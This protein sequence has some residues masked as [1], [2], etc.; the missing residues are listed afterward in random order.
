MRQVFKL[1]NMIRRLLLSKKSIEER[2]AKRKGQCRKCGQCCTG[3]KYLTQNQL[4]EVYEKRSKWCHKDFPIDRI[5]IIAF[6][7]KDCGY[8]FD[9]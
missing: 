2:L 4:C 7:I 9:R 5:D 6:G 3:C 8:S 1:L